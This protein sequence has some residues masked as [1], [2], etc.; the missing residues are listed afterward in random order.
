MLIQ[1]CQ[2][3]IP[4]QS[5]TVRPYMADRVEYLI[6]KPEMVSAVSEAQ[7]CFLFC[8]VL[9]CFFAETFYDPS[10]PILKCQICVPKYLDFIEENILISDFH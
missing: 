10:M 1:H 5:Q 9:F 2:S 3:A 4:S 6:S 7:H 8:F